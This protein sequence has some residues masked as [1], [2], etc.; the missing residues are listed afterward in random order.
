ARTRDDIATGYFDVAARPLETTTLLDE[1]ANMLVTLP[2][3]P[4]AH[5]PGPVLYYR[6]I[7][8][9]FDMFPAASRSLTSA[10]ERL[11]GPIKRFD[12][13]R[14]RYGPRLLQAAAVVGGLGTVVLSVLTCWAIAGIA[15][16]SGA[17]VLSAARAGALWALMPAALFFAPSVDAITTFLV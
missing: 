14:A 8:A 1:Y 15:R 2:V 6:S 9:A 4:R 17:D 10:L 5:P 12:G 7:I 11:P 13:G 3:H 16:A